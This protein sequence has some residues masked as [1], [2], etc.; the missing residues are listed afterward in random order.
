MGT[1]Q[2]F[3]MKQMGTHKGRI[4]DS[5]GERYSSILQ[6]PF[7]RTQEAPKKDAIRIETGP[8]VCPT[9]KAAG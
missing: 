4:N 2:A 8:M 3:N 7:I 6:P 1:Q 5:L 9:I